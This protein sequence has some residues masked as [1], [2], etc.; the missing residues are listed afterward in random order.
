MQRPTD[1]LRSRPTKADQEARANFL[2]HHAERFSDYFNFHTDE[3]GVPLSV[4]ESTRKARL[5]VTRLELLSMLEQHYR[6]L[7]GRKWYKRLWRYLTAPRGSGPVRLTPATEGEIERG[8][9]TPEARQ[10]G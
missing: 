4:I 1:R 8:E 10:G 6:A 2:G 5:P 3:K 7:E 9:A